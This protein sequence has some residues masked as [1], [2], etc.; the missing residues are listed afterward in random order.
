MVGHRNAAGVAVQLV[1]AFVAPQCVRTTSP[2]ESVVTEPPIKKIFAA[3][4]VRHTSRI[5]LQEVVSRTTSEP[6]VP[7]IAAQRVVTVASVQ[8]VRAVVTD[9]QSGRIAHQGVVAGSAEQTVIAPTSPQLSIAGATGEGVDS[10]AGTRSPN[11]IRVI[12]DQLIVAVL[13]K[14]KIPAAL[15]A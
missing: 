13:A 3:R 11:F 15:S 9:V 14:E 7:S 4:S 10:V 12:A 1:V 2:N 6:I 8:V 5:A